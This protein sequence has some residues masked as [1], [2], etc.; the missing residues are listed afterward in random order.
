MISLAHN[1]KEIGHVIITVK[2]PAVQKCLIFPI[3]PLPN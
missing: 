2:M 1:Y 3:T